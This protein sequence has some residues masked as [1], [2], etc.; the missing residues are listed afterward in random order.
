LG[1]QPQLSLSDAK[2][3]GNSYWYSFIYWFSSMDKP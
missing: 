2:D 1:A 3:V